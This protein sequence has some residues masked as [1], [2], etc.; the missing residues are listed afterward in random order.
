MSEMCDN[1]YD[2]FTFFTELDICC[3]LVSQFVINFELYFILTLYTSNKGSSFV[4]LSLLFR[5]VPV[6]DIEVHGKK[7]ELVYGIQRDR[8]IRTCYDLF[9]VPT[10]DKRR[11]TAG[12]KKQSGERGNTSLADHQQT[13]R[14]EASISTLFENVEEIKSLE[15]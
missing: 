12:K 5:G 3:N 13:L 8:K 2:N 11:N 10:S 4:F 15:L 9:P 1:C 7:V 14:L 6:A